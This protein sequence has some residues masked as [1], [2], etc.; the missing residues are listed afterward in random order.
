[1]KK[2]RSK[3][4]NLP[5]IQQALTNQEWKFDGGYIVYHDLE[6]SMFVNGAWYAFEEQ[7]K[8]INRLKKYLKNCCAFTDEYIEEIL[9]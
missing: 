8:R 6:T 1:M 3:F 5:D 7:Q 4:E 2:L 9:K